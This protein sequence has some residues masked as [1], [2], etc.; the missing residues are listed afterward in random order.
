M[1]NRYE[2]LLILD[3]KGKEDGAKDIIER[4]EKAFTK[5][6]AAIEQIQ[7]LDKRQFSY[8]AGHL[9]HGYY[10][11]F[12][13]KAEPTVI[14]ALKNKFRLDEE[15]YRQHYLRLKSKPAPAVAAA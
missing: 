8:A 9:D 11:N 14:D 1:K 6:G 13:F 10:V 5:E 2:A 7:R 15:V 4:L 12:I 3:T